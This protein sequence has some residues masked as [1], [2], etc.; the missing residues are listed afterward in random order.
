M[1]SLFQAHPNHARELKFNHQYSISPPSNMNLYQPNS[2][3]NSSTDLY[4]PCDSPP[5]DLSDSPEES[6][7]F[8]GVLK[9]MNQMLMEEEDLENKP[10]MFHE[11]SALQAAEKSFYDVLGQKYPPSPDSHP[12]FQSHPIFV[13]KTHNREDKSDDECVHQERS[14]N[15]LLARN[16]ADESEDSDFVMYDKVLLCAALNPG[17]HDECPFEEAALEE[18][19]FQQNPQPKEP[20]PRSRKHNQK[21]VVDLTSLLTQCAQAIS[22]SDIIT[23]DGL[24]KQI[25]EYSWPHGDG[26]ER[27]AHYFANAI[28]ARLAGTGTALY[29]AFV[30][31]RI[32]AK[33]VLKAYQAY[34]GACPFHKMSNIFANKSI[35]RLARKAT[36]LHVIDFGILYG[37]QWPCLIQGLSLRPGGPPKLR[38]TGIDFP[39][40]GFRPAERVEDT[41]RR[42]ADYCKRFNVPFEYNAIA[43]KWESIRLEDLK[44]DRDGNEVL[45]VNSLYRLRNVTDEIVEA[46]SPRDVVLNLIKRINPDMFMHGVVNGSY[47]APFF[48]TRFREAL[49]HFSTLFDM[50]EATMAREDMER[51]VHEQE[52]FARDAMNVI[53]CEGGARIERPE[54]Y[55]QWQARNVRAGFRQ[56]GLYRNIVKEVSRKVRA[57]YH[58]DYLVDEDSN[59]M[60]QGWKGRV[61]YALSCWKPTQ[62]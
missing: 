40:P 11:C 13:K 5:L 1:D 16:Y 17:L 53:A 51:M 21:K 60:L 32:M 33:D 56:V 22:T 52:V 6:D 25:R 2:N 47:S 18:K 41:G 58:G 27:L 3:P 24:L 34:V 46:H 29:S 15:K 26:T 4:H 19:K 49:F 38:I 57:R 20:R 37:F 30:T 28:E 12:P 42:L 10:C 59:W 44:I 9:F 62:D 61:L 55:R 43:K 14:T 35:G 50:F 8:D 23:A 36:R 31:R 54:T 45:V 39:Q 48:V 7:Y